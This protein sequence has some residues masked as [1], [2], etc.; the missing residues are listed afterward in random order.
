MNLRSVI[1]VLQRQNPEMLRVFSSEEL[2][3]ALD[4]KPS[5]SKRIIIN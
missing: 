3:W 1:V 5:E 2:S 4:M